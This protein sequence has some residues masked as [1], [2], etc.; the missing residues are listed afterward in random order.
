MG[1]VV[2]TSSPAFVRYYRLITGAQP[3]EQLDRRLDLHLSDRH[4]LDV[5]SQRESLV[6]GVLPRL[7]IDLL[8]Q[9]Q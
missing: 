4:A 1:L 9:P 3:P 5:H 2:L 8:A 7:G 6:A